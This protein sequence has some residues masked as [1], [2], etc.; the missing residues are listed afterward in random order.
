[1][2][3]RLKGLGFGIGAILLFIVI[4]ILL[5]PWMDQKGTTPDERSMRFPG[6]DLIQNPLRV[7]NRGI[8]FKPARTRFI[9][10]SCKRGL[11][12]L[13]CIVIPGSKTWLVVKWRRMK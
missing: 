4:I 12:N 1:M 8:L 10:G 11:I 2:K 13:A 9:P 7:V 6:D 5:L 3:K